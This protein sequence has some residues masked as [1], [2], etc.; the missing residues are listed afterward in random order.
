MPNFSTPNKDCIRRYYNKPIIRYLKDKYSCK[1]IYYGL[2]SPD[3][4]DISE[5][6]DYISDVVA[7]QCRDYGAVSTPDQPTDEVDKLIE[8]LNTWEAAG[9]IDN[10]VVYD[11]YMEEVLFRG[12]D[13]SASGSIDYTHTNHITL[14]NLDFCN[15]ITSPQEYIT[16]DGD[17]ITKYKL[18]LIDKILEYQYAVSNQ[19]DKFVLFLTVQASYTGAELR[20]YLEANKTF[21]GKYESHQ[22]TEYYKTRHFKLKHFIEENLYQKIKAYN[23][24]PQFMPTV[25]YKGIRNVDMMHFAVMCIRPQEYKKQ[26]GVFV[27]NQLVNNITDSLP[28]LPDPDNSALKHFPDDIDGMNHPNIDFMYTFSQSKNVN[29]Y[30]TE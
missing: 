25:F 6:I 8:K 10:Y 29:M 17:R 27:Y 26:G 28:I 20:D 14:F 13:N 30:W 3:A 7:F 19:S 4:E 2:P 22:E 21:L 16:K 11:G 12:F 9:K 23:Y 5:W 15:S 1:I 18:E 24:I